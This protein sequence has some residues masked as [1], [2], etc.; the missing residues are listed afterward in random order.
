MIAT[1]LVLAG[2]LSS[3][4]APTKSPVTWGV[5]ITLPGA[6]GPALRVAVPCLS[7]AG[8]RAADKR[9]LFQFYVGLFGR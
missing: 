3:D 4:G 9:E 1:V 7:E 2:L 8:V 5:P 6:T